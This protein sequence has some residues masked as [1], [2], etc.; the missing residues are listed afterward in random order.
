MRRTGPVTPC[1]K[2]VP[3]LA[4][5]D[6]TTDAEAM[7]EDT[8]QTGTRLDPRDPLVVDTTALGRRP[9]T[10]R[11]DSRTVPAP[12]DFGLT[13]I[14]VPEGTEIRLDLRLE[15]VMEGVLVTGTAEVPLSGECARCLDELSSE[16]EV[17][18]QELYVYPESETASEE[19]PRLEGDL[20]DVEQA[21]RD[22]VVLTLPLS[23]LCRE[24]CPGLCAQCG[25]RLADVEPDHR[26]EED[27]DPRWQALRGFFDRTNDDQE[28]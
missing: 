23:P 4:D 12:T 19:E 18:F 17:N 10:M 9:G 14:G 24:D 16:L 25:A 22:A 2:W 7:P 20:L 15:A 3:S 5:P 26:H 8:Q 1:Q 28:G 27:I 21:L 13:M 11:R 6:C